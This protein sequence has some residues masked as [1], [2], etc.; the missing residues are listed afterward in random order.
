MNIGVQGLANMNWQFRFKLFT[1]LFE[2]CL[3]YQHF[4]KYKFGIAVHVSSSSVGKQPLIIYQTLLLIFLNG[5][6]IYSLQKGLPFL[7]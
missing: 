3:D 5:Y 7:M 2:M 4:V 6:D 1:N